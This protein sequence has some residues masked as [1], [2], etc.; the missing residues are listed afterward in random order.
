[1]A[2][3]V[4]SL[5]TSQA[6]L[7]ACVHLCVCESELPFGQ[8]GAGDWAVAHYIDLCVRS[9]GRKQPGVVDQLVF[10]ILGVQRG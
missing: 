8:A 2:V 3:D 7:C 10:S 1:M 9:R 6:H 4:T 5:P